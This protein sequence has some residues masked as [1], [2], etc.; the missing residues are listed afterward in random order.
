M[1]PGQI[2]GQRVPWSEVVVGDDDRSL[3]FGGLDLPDAGPWKLDQVRVE[4]FPEVVFAEVVVNNAPPPRDITLDLPVRVRLSEPLAGRPVVD[5]TCGRYAP[6]Q[7]RPN[8]AAEMTTPWQRACVPHPGVI[9]LIW[10]AAMYTRPSH[11]DVAVNAD[12]ATVTLC[13]W[14]GGGKLAGSNLVTVCPAPGLRPGMALLD[15][16]KS[17]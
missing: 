14:E 5:T 9:V 13:T 15:G 4:L 6:L 8:Y 11:I 12:T 3:A 2:Y 7:P 1:R 10:Y 16:A 17:S